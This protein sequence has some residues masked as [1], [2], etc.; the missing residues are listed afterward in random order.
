[1]YKY[2]KSKDWLVGFYEDVVADDLGVGV[3]AETWGHNKD[4]LLDPKCSSDK[5]K[6]VYSVLDLNFGSG[7]AFSYTSDHSKWAVSVDTSK[8]WF[9]ISDI[10]R[11]NT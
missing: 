9:C 2:G 7:Y 11:V 1:M 5:T 3:Y 4:G 6:N 8:K 10:N